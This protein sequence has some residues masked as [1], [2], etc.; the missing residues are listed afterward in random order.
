[1]PPKDKPVHVY[2]EFTVP[3]L[4]DY[5]WEIPDEYYEVIEPHIYS[6]PTAFYLPWPMEALPGVGDEITICSAP[7]GLFESVVKYRAFRFNG[8]E[9]NI[10]ISMKEPSSE[11]M[12]RPLKIYGVLQC[13]ET[14]F[15]FE[16]Q[17]PITD[18]LIAAG[19]P[20]SQEDYE[21]WKK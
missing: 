10:Y 1:M 5:K 7:I 9:I 21:A 18:V 2:L 16:S 6:S 15:L 8:R 14:G 13:A 19:L 3:C 12:K 4:F 11:E 20:A 17:K